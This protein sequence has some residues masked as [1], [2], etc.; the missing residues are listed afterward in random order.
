MVRYSLRVVAVVLTMLLPA[1]AQEPAAFP[2]NPAPLLFV[3]TEMHQD[4][5]MLEPAPE[6]AKEVYTKTEY[7]AAFDKI[8]AADRKGQQLTPAELRKRLKPG[9]IVV[10]RRDERPLDDAY[11]AILSDNAV[12]LTGVL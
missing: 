7:P 4:R 1:S 10:V 3:V 11:L 12:I 6:R 9:N 5:L 8:G 2:K